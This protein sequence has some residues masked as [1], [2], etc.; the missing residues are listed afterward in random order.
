[1]KTKD[2][3]LSPAARRDLLRIRAWYR[4]ELGPGAAARALATIESAL[5][6]LQHGVTLDSSTRP[7]LP[8][9]VYRVVAKQHVV[10]FEMDGEIALVLRIVHGARDLT[11]AL[12][13][14]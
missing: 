1:M 14:T 4:N 10:L 5:S 11:S 8:L 9:G 12:A 7:D 6:Q 3:R 13:D 2:F